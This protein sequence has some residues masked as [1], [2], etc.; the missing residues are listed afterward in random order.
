MRIYNHE[1]WRICASCGG[2]FDLRLS[3][4]CDHC[5]HDNEK[6]LTPFKAPLKCSEMK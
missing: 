4:I 5:G 6:N 3:P 1:V 2:W